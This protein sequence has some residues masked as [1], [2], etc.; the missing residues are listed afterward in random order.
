M[1]RT[2]NITKYYNGIKAL[3]DVSITLERGKIYGFIG[4]NGAGKTTLIRMITGLAFPTKGEIEL[5]GKNGKKEIEVQRRKIG[6]MVERPILFEDLTA[7]ENISLQ[8]ILYG[9]GHRTNIDSMLSRVGLS[10]TG[11]KKVKDFSLGMKQRLGIALAMVQ[12]PEILILDEPVNGLDPVGMVEVRELLKELNREY[13]ITML[14]SSHILLELYQLATDYIIINKGKVVDQLTLEEL[15]DKCKKYILIETDDIEKA[16]AIF[17]EKLKTR[18]FQMLPSGKIKLF[19]YKDDIKLVAR[20]LHEGGVIT[21]KFV[22]VGESLE[23]YYI[24]LI[25]DSK[26]VEYTEMGS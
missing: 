22:T 14:I 15:N 8:S 10:N 24:K 6:N 25:G 12:E 4:Q 26:H 11:N 18:D 7:K 16:A 21:T 20:L 17:R 9:A 1:L 2:L 13:N 19:D 23:E 3:D 5:F